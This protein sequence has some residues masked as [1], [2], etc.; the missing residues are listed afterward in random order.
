[1][2]N[3]KELNEQSKSSDDEDE[4][5][6]DT[7]ESENLQSDETNSNVANNKSVNNAIK[8]EIV[9]EWNID[10]KNSG[11]QASATITTPA[12][13]QE[14]DV[15]IKQEKETLEMDSA[16]EIYGHE[17]IKEHSCKEC[18]YKASNRITLDN[19]IKRVHFK[20]RDF[21]CQWCDYK[22]SFQQQ[23]RL[24]CQQS[25]N[26]TIEPLED[27]SRKSSSE[28]SDSGLENDGQNNSKI[29]YTFNNASGTSGGVSMKKETP[30]N[31]ANSKDG[32]LVVTNN[33]NTMACPSA[34]CE[35][36]SGDRNQVKQHVENTHQVK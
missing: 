30:D 18:D 8:T 26:Q 32:S 28:S 33:N 7:D 21:P 12:I 34:N 22:T 15:V 35:Y 27:F 24:H 2:G 1:M 19:H 17:G 4:E 16:K 5:D 25:H 23:L 9:T 3:T 10:H 29:G 11:D 20:M 6:D 13:K 31:H 14:T 36:T